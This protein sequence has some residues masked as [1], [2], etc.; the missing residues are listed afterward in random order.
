MSR[1]KGRYVAKVIIDFDVERKSD[2][3]SLE[4][5]KESFRG[6]PAEL[7]GMIESETDLENP[8]IT[9]ELLDLYEVEGS[10]SE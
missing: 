3:P 2:T 8:V 5:I 4:Q 10:E 9:E 1:I 6:F 7:K